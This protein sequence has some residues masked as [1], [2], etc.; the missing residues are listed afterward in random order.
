MLFPTLRL[1]LAHSHLADS[2]VGLCSMT[3]S[4][5]LYKRGVEYLSHTIARLDRREVL[6]S[7]F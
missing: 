4:R 1:A 3:L 7:G 2:A 6:R 5:P